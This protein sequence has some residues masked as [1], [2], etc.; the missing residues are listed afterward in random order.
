MADFDQAIAL[1]PRF[2]EAHNCRGIVWKD[3]GDLNRAI[4]DFSQSIKLD[5]Q[6]YGAYANRG[7]ARLRQGKEAEAQKDFDQCLKLNPK[8]KPQLEQ[9]IKEVKQQ[10]AAKQ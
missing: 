8:L 10:L 9:R 3:K 7:L 5:P 4:A 6:Y 2:A 1:D